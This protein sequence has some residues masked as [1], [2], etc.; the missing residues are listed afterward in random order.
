MSRAQ[1]EKRMKRTNV[2]TL[3][4]LAIGIG[5]GFHMSVAGAVNVAYRSA[6]IFGNAAATWAGATFGS[7]HADHGIYWNSADGL[8]HVHKADNTE[9]AIPNAAVAPGGGYATAAYAG[10][11]LTQRTTLNM[12]GSGV[13]C[14]DNAGSARTD[15]TIKTP[16]TFNVVDYGAVGGTTD[17][18][19]AIQNALNACGSGGGGVVK[20]MS[21]R[22]KITNTITLKSNCALVGAGMGISV[23]AP[24][25]SATPPN[26]VIDNDWINGNTNITLRDFTVDRS[27]PN[28]QHAILL[29]GVTNLL[30]DGIEVTGLDSTT[31]G[32]LGI[33]GVGPTVRL[34]SKNVRVVNSR[35]ASC[36]N[37]GIQFSY[38]LNGVAAN[39]TFDDCYREAVGVEPESAV[40]AK[41]ISIVGNSFTTG[42]IPAGGSSTGVIIVTTSS[43]GTIDGVSI[44]GNSI[45]NT[46][47]TLTNV[48]PGIDILGANDNVTITANNIN[49]TNGPCISVGNSSTTTIGVSIIG[50]VLTTCGEGQAGTFAQGGISLRAAIQATVVGNYIKGTHHSASVYESQSGA[51]RNL[52]AWN[53]L[54]DSTPVTLLAGS[55]TFVGQNSVNRSTSSARVPTAADYTLAGNEDTVA[56]TSTAAARTITLPAAASVSEGRMFVVKD[57]SGGAGSNN[58]T[59]ARAGSDTID[60]AS[61][62]V[63]STNY[64]IVRLYSD[65][66]SKWFTR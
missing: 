44:A 25:F 8:P 23:I 40:T 60:G 34:Q 33:S 3:W 61:S 58:I 16:G 56:V 55:H 35:F 48:N 32:V 22:Q 65:G 27:G 43:G 47:A 66:V 9:Y 37:F 5:L 45:R 13:S 28:V 63:I 36:D 6:I 49:G 46:L 19:T 20:L 18:T 4:A 12:T 39:N 2:L 51:G 62:L 50:N 31:S 38:V 11:P 24:V 10:T 57:E 1:G 21:S 26:R 52:I 14:V 53:Q 42:T 41:N 30:I 29:N 7:T 54:L 15:C 59:I 64:G 17:D